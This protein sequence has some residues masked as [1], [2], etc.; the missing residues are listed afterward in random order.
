M[1]SNSLSFSMSLTCLYTAFLVNKCLKLNAVFETNRTQLKQEFTE[2]YE[3]QFFFT[4]IL[5]F[6]DIYEFNLL[7]TWSLLLSDPSFKS[8]ALQAKQEK[9]DGSI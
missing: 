4:V 5:L 7:F 2:S 1:R 8:D 6:L 9:R 3:K